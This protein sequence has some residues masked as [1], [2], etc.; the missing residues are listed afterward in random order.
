MNKFSNFIYFMWKVGQLFRPAENI[1]WF[2]L[3]VYDIACRVLIGSLILAF[4][5]NLF[6]RFFDSQVF[7]LIA[8]FSVALIAEI[9]GKKLNIFYTSKF[10]RNIARAILPIFLFFTALVLL[11]AAASRKLN[12]FAELALLI[13]CVILTLNI[14]IL[15]I[16]TPVD[17][18]GDLK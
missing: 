6:F 15:A 14:L 3:T 13:G 9:F 2:G 12:S 8:S 17:I 11:G 10:R 1:R 5:L 16:R 7:G 4:P 18:N